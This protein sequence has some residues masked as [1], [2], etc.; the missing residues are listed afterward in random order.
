MPLIVVSHDAAS[1]VALWRITEPEQVLFK[2]AAP[3]IDTLGRIAQAASA[4]R[5]MEVLAVRATLSSIG[6]EDDD[7]LYYPSGKPCLK[8][9]E[10]FISITHSGEYAGVILAPQP[11]GIDAE[12]IGDKV[13]RVADK[14]LTEKEKKAID[15]Q[16]NRM[17]TLIWASKEAIYKMRGE[18]GLSLLDI[19]T[20]PPEKI[21]EKGHLTARIK[22][23]KE[24]YHM[25]YFTLED[26]FC[27]CSYF[28][29]DAN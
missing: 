1:T 10:R 14:F 17:L 15:L 7:L 27:V 16:D 3:S 2:L 6:V 23:E 29:D 22:G 13:M 25:T 20:Y 5:R 24:I 19:E 9:S 11:V 18:K 28:E 12:K 26:Y 21:E 4:K 8:D